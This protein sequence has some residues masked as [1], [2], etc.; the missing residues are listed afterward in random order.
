MALIKWQPQDELSLFQKSIEDLFDD[1][2]ERKSKSF[3]QN[4]GIVPNVDISETKDEY[5]ITSELPGVKKEDIKVTIDNNI[6]TIKG[7]K[8]HEKEEKGK[9]YLRRERTY[10][11]F[12][13]S[14]TLTPNVD[15]N[16]IKSTFKDGVLEIKLPKTE[17]SKSK[18]IQIE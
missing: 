7:E 18:E 8:K 1:F 2:F 10:G 17:S 11:S 5:I 6:L 9:N 12:S 14:F 15:V 13:R 4:T 3:L 16:K